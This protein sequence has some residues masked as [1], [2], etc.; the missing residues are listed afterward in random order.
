[1]RG[2]DEARQWLVG[3]IAAGNVDGIDVVVGLLDLLDLE[4]LAR[5]GAEHDA[6]RWRVAAGGAY[7]ALTQVGE[8]EHPLAALAPDVDDPGSWE[9]LGAEF[10]PQA[11]GGTWV[12]SVG[13]DSDVA[14]WVNALAQTPGRHVRRP[15]DRR[16]HRPPA[17]ARGAHRG[18]R[19]QVDRG[20]ADDPPSRARPYAERVH[21]LPEAAV[22]F[23]ECV[24]PPD[25]TEP[26]W[27]P[28]IERPPFDGLIRTVPD[29]RGVTVWS[30]QPDVVRR[31]VIDGR[32]PWEAAA[33][34]A[35]PSQQTITW[36]S[37]FARIDHAG[38]GVE[39][40]EVCDEAAAL[41]AGAH[42]E[43]RSGIRFAV[44][45]TKGRPGGFVAL[46]HITT[47]VPLTDDQ[48]ET[49]RSA[50][51]DATRCPRPDPHGTLAAVFTDPRWEGDR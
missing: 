3:A 39:F 36:G 21:D 30:Y 16:P 41:L 35:T 24:V 31:A 15:V 11:S 45:Y 6:D 22:T 9:A 13:Q 28:D 50:G 51:W 44:C 10:I 1:M 46:R 42:H 2:E 38:F 14:K 19:P 43:H 25:D 32:D 49:A 27:L 47:L 12:W 33:S 4:R 8:Y 26:L 40:G 7:H 20:D 5:I 17:G 34:T 18:G 23:D 29:D 37:K 48:F